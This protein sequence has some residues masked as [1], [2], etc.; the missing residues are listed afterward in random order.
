MIKLN[1]DVIIYTTVYQESAVKQVVEFSKQ[2]HME[3]LKIRI[4]PDYH[5]GNGSVIG[6][7]IQLKDKVVPNLV[8]VD[9]GCGIKVVKIKESSIDFEKL[10][11]V[12]RKNIPSGINNRENLDDIDFDYLYKCFK[13]VNEVNANNFNHDAVSLSL[14]TLGGGN[15]FI[16]VAVDDEGSNYLLIHTGSR[17]LGAKVAKY[18]QDIAIKDNKRKDINGLINQ[19]KMD[20]RYSEIQ[21]AVIEFRENEVIIPNDLAYLEGK[22]FD[23]Y[24]HDMK[25]TQ[26][27]A[28]MNREII[29]ET[30]INHMNWTVEDEFDSI[31]NYIDTDSM[32]LRKGATSA[33]Q[34]ERLVVPINMR[35]GSLICVG[36]GNSDWNYSAPH[37]AGRV[38][39][40]TEANKKLKLDDFKKE[41]SNVWSSCVSD[42]TLDES[43]MAYKPMEEITEAIN[44]T[45]EILKVVKPIYNFKAS[46]RFKKK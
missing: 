9:I 8:G 30:I 43:P 7:T 12:I 35:D 16:E 14:G 28:V 25:L 10:D 20:N 1:D 2:P 33:K 41:M 29:T 5:A 13:I 18:H 6:T 38:Y 3:G 22:S 32:I 36:K 19:M 39:S 37:G 17:Q 26:E 21:K 44:D 27:F 24:I 46:D 34:G 42:D 45:V 31:H 40:R 11:G 23:K 15:H 4:M